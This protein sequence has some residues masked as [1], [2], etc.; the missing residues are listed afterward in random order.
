MGRRSVH[1][2]DCYSRERG[3]TAS[4]GGREAGEMWRGGGEGGEGR[5]WHRAHHLPSPPSLFFFLPSVQRLWEVATRKTRG[6]GGVDGQLTIPLFPISAL[7]FYSY[8]LIF[9]RLP[10]P[11]VAVAI[12]AL[13]HSPTAPTRTIVIEQYRP[14]IGKTIIE[15]PAGLIEQ[16]EGPEKTALRELAEETGYA[17]GSR[18]GGEG[19]IKSVSGVMVSDPGECSGLKRVRRA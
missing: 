15:F 19:T 11:S 16:G 12:F 7:P 13:L 1:G 10:H 3:E 6:S 4:G 8:V 2:G 5:N 17:G 18:E 14:P 9:P